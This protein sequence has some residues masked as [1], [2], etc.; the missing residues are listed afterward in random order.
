MSNKTYCDVCDKEVSG[1]YTYFTLQLNQ[2]GGDNLYLHA[3]LCPMHRQAFINLLV[4][5][6]PKFKGGKK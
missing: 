6:L 5:F 2:M 4:E 3:D 1:S